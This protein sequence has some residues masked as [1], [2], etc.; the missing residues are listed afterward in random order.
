[1]CL[2]IGCTSMDPTTKIA[3]KLDLKSVSYILETFGTEAMHQSIGTSA[4][5]LLMIYG[6]YFF[7]TYFSSKNTV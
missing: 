6:G 7:I 1:M 4:V 5:I 2:E 3:I